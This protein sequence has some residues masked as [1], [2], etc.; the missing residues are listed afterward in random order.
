[1]KKIS[2]LVLD[3]LFIS[4]WVGLAATIMFI[5]SSFISDLTA[6]RSDWGVPG[7]YGKQFF[8]Y[9]VLLWI[10][11]TG[12]MVLDCYA[13][14]GNEDYKRKLW[15][16]VLLIHLFVVGPTAY[17]LG[18]FRPKTLGMTGGNTPLF[19]R[20]RLHLLDALF[21]LSFWGSIAFLGSGVATFAFA[22]S[23][24]S[25]QLL[26]VITLV[27]LPLSA[28]TT[29]VLMTILLLDAMERPKEVW[30]RVSLLRLLNP[31]SWVFGMRKYY[32]HVLRP[33]LRSP[34]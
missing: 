2:I 25:F 34:G 33:E 18:S 22:N 32:L 24:Y 1:M 15:I 30:E 17:Y 29:F 19:F 28:I 6:P 9:T 5:V 4:T 7:G 31:W 8:W 26:A 16:K 10:G 23:V 13:A 11:L 27:L 20:K 21:F 3:S 14:P 12:S